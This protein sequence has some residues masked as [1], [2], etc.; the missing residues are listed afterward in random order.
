MKKGGLLVLTGCSPEQAAGTV[1]P[2]ASLP[3]WPVCI[4]GSMLCLP[5]HLI[6][7]AT[8]ISSLILEVAPATVSG[9]VCV[10]L[11]FGH[12]SHLTV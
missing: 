8:A 5:L 11:P 12:Y 4:C 7:A 1:A 2:G 3:G 9:S 6:L 10:V